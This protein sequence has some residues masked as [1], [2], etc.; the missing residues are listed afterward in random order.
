[1]TVVENPKTG[2]DMKY[3]LNTWYHYDE[4]AKKHFERWAPTEAAA[5]GHL[6]LACKKWYDA[7]GKL[8]VSDDNYQS[9]EVTCKECWK[10]WK[11]ECQ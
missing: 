9:F 11:V 1:M 3:E 5:A 8:H 4:A 10:S 6:V 2:A 7:T